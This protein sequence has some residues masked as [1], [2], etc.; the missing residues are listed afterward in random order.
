MTKA[1]IAFDGASSLQVAGSSCSSRS[2][3]PSSSVMPRRRNAVRIVRQTPA[4][5][6]RRTLPSTTVRRVSQLV[7]EDNEPSGALGRTSTVP[8]LYAVIETLME[9]LTISLVRGTHH[10]DRP[11]DLTAVSDDASRVG[12]ICRFSSKSSRDKWPGTTRPHEHD[13]CLGEGRSG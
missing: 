13:L 6:I 9:P 5:R 3:L 12:V 7:V 1:Y 8:F 4:A 10:W 11:S 2:K